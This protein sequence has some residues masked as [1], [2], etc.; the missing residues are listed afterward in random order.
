M[1]IVNALFPL[2]FSLTLFTSP[3]FLVVAILKFLSLK[4]I[5]NLE[6][7]KKQ[8][9]KSWK[10]LFMPLLILILLTIL[11]GLERLIFVIING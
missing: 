8:K 2:I 5:S 4:K 1:Q 6:E 3:I 7:K 11:W 9:R 10:I